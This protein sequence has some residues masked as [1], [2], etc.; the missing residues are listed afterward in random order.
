[1][2]GELYTV[3][4]AANILKV[5]QRTVRNWINLGILDAIKIGRNCQH[6]HWRI[7]KSAIDAILGSDK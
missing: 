4:E 3:R 7:R 2:N 5:S 6:D 1:M